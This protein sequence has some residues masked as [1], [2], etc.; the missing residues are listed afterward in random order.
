M[1][2]LTSQSAL[3]CCSVSLYAATRLVLKGPKSTSKADNR[4]MMVDVL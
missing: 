3:I 1:K 2:I 4:A